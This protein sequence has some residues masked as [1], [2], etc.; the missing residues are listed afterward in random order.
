[1]KT[2]IL[3]LVFF[4][5][6]TEVAKAQIMF[7]RT[8]GGSADDGGS[9]VLQ[10]DDGGYIVAAQTF[11]FGT[12]TSDIYI[13][14]TDAYGNE[15]WTKTYGGNAWDAPNDIKK[16]HD[17]CY[18]IVGKTSSYGAGASDAFLMK[19]DSNGDSLWFK[20]YGGIEDDGANS[21]DICADSGFIICGSTCSYS[22]VFSA[23][24]LIKTN[25]NGDT[26]WTSTYEEKDY[27]NASSIITTH[28][29]GFLLAGIAET[30]GAPGADGLVIRTNSNGDTL[31]MKIYGGLSYDI[32]TSVCEDNNG[33]FLLCGTTYNLASGSYD[34]Y[35][36]K[37]NSNGQELWSKTYGGFDVDNAGSIK[38]TNDNAFIIA[39]STESYGVGGKD[40]L[41]L[42]IDQNGDTL[43]SK[44]FG[45]TSDDVAGCVRQTN[46]N[47]F[48]VSGYTKSCS[49]NSD[50]YLIKTDASG[51]S[52]FEKVIS[53]KE[54]LNVFPNP[55]NGMFN[56][57]IPENLK[58]NPQIEVYNM[59][60]QR[61]FEN[62]YY[63]ISSEIIEVDIRNYPKGT[64]VMCIKNK[65]NS[66]TSKV[67]I[68]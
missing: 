12:G 16:T 24:Y 44:T 10:T 47:G 23:V 68:N 54:T 5:L 1:M 27:N 30:G 40:V 49:A 7:E 67:I 39:G 56:V 8:Y 31:W 3:I 34:A 57:N 26:L 45:G 58:S 4:L 11:S 20:T 35:I 46:D 60:G 50:V 9:S 59:Q 18:V 36:L 32:F 65:F 64:Y 62:Q 14:K 41:F 17:N 25:S 29:G 51:F 48:I 61:V 28:D 43:W 42:K 55:S 13:I 15:L 21:I 37:I 63:G 38:Y 6:A 66:A 2:K 19:I 53:V 33:N 22:N 52:G